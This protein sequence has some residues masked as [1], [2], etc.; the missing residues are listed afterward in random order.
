MNVCQCCLNDRQLPERHF[1]P[2]RYSSIRRVYVSKLNLYHCFLPC[3]LNLSIKQKIN[4]NLADKKHD[5]YAKLES[6]TTDHK[7]ARV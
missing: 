1:R 4:S 2:I 7:G 6:F 5:A 3:T